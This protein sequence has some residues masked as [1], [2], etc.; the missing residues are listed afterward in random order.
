M[1]SPEQFF[2]EDDKKIVKEFYKNVLVTREFD[3]KQADYI[4]N[5]FFDGQTSE[6]G[7]LPKK[8]YSQV[9]IPKILQIIARMLLLIY[10]IYILQRKSMKESK[11]KKI[12]YLSHKEKASK[13]HFD[14]QIKTKQEQEAKQNEKDEKRKRTNRYIN[15]F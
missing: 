3:D 7:R 4:I 15:V 2:N 10:Q 11:Q 8:N 1:K 6:Y 14:A 5:D 13:D 9:H 12:N